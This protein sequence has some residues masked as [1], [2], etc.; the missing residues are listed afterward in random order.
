MWPLNRC[1]PLQSNLELYS[2]WRQHLHHEWWAGAHPAFLG[3]T[4]LA[5][6]T[7]TSPVGSDRVRPAGFPPFPPPSRFLDRTID[8]CNFILF[9]AFYAWLDRHDLIDHFIRV[10]TIC[11]SRLRSNFRRL[12]FFFS[13]PAFSIL[14]FRAKL[15]R[16]GPRTHTWIDNDYRKASKELENFEVRF[17]RFNLIG[18]KGRER[19]MTHLNFIIRVSHLLRNVR[20]ES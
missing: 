12:P 18:Q 16:D 17:F 20:F 19:Q 1:L 6:R 4:F 3:S 15:S 10:H 5:P 13:R 8:L 14:H 2:R 11:S 9:Q 7:G